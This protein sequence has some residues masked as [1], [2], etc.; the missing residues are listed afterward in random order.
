M[1]RKTNFFSV[2]QQLKLNLCRPFLNVSRSLCLYL[3][4]IRYDSSKRAISPSQKPLSIQHTKEKNMHVLSGIRT[5]EPRNRVASDVQASTA[6]PLG[7]AGNKLETLNQYVLRCYHSTHECTDILSGR[8]HGRTGCAVS[9][10]ELYA[11]QNG[12]SQTSRS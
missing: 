12:L 6:G 10:M 9:Q 8:V 1:D 3:A 11:E 7:S 2:V 5:R 4:H